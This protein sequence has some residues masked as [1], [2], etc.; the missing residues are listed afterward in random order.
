MEGDVR[1]AILGWVQKWNESFKRES[2]RL[3]SSRGGPNVS[4]L[5]LGGGPPPEPLE[6][7]SKGGGGKVSRI[8]GGPGETPGNKKNKGNLRIR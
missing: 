6:T 1:F 5:N 2:R 3:R 7:W 4:N 8:K